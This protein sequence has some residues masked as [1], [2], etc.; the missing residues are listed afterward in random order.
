MLPNHNTAPFR[1]RTVLL[2]GFYGRN[3]F[4]DD[5]MA[6][7]LAKLLLEEKGLYL[8]ISTSDPAPFASLPRSHVSF[9]PRTAR[10]LAGHLGAVD[11]LLQGGGSIFHDAYEGRS[12]FPYWIN[13]MSWTALFILAR[14]RGVQ[15]V[16]AGAGIGPFHSAIPRA[17]S[18]AAF[19]QCRA[20]GV[21]DQASCT[22]FQEIHCHTPLLRGRDLAILSSNAFR[23]SARLAAKRKVLGISVCSL[24]PYFV[25]DD[26]DKKY[27][28][29][30]ASALTQF[31]A[32]HD[33]EIVFFSL[34]TG[35]G[36]T[37][38]DDQVSDIIIPLLPKHIPV[39]RCSYQSNP[40]EYIAHFEK[41]DWFIATKYHAAVTAWLAD[42]DLAI[43]PYHRKLTDFADEIGLPQS[44]RMVAHDQVAPETW[45]ALLLS[46]ARSEKPAGLLPPLEAMQQTRACVFSVLDHLQFAE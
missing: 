26:I 6:L 13:L 10:A 5:L 24:S 1:K 46:F 33:C 31:S 3:N 7:S 44:R 29:T 22:S 41:C 39:R 2:C 34:Y 35:R 38:E 25:G 11:I 8:L 19:A 21:R 14:L 30:L 36:L 32:E 17:I 4:G 15:V 16:V 23:S 12:R 43:I 27:W 40:E 45:L 42:C 28:S 9:I 18:R 20:V 37:S